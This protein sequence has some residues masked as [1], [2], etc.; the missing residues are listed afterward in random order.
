MRFDANL[1][2]LFPDLAMLDR[3][4]AA[5][6]AGFDAIELWWP[7]AGPVPGA[8]EVDDLVDAVGSARLRLVLVNLWL[9]DPTAGEHGLVALPGSTPR[10]RENVDAAAEV[11][12]RLGGSVVNCHFG[13]PPPDLP[14]EVLEA[15][16]IENLAYAAPLMA[17][18]GAALVIEP[19]NSI[20]FPR[21]G[22]TRV[23]EAVDLT[24]RATAASGVPVRIL[25]DVYHVQ[26]AEGDLVARI[27]AFAPDIGH[28]QIAD[29]P[30][31]GRPG[32]GEIAF[33]RVLEALEAAGYA[34]F[35]GLEYRPSPDPGD[36]FAWLPPAAR[37]S[38]APPAQVVRRG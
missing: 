20:D 16:A 3:P 8:H 31:R 17:A 22:L 25:F 9:G 28:V 23:A 38:A 33:D 7:F 32:T 37:R 11:V 24:R 19:L 10:F 2:I 30:D 5:A 18:A 29:V 12:R 26:R 36:T 35:V 4:A 15:T 21:Y 34:G 6:A 13:N 27:R 14:R 1:S